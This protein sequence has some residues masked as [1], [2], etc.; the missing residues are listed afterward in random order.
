MG[1]YIVELKSKYGD[2]IKELGEGKNAGS[3]KEIIKEVMQLAESRKVK[4]TKSEIRDALMVLAATGK[5]RI[6][7]KVPKMLE[8][9]LK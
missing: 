3:L 4:S 6:E 9:K 8:V 7:R 5:L 2:L 1:N